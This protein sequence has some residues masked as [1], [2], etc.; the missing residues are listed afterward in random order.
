ML[1]IGPIGWAA[2]PLGLPIWVIGTTV[3]LLRLPAR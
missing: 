1:V 2:L 3:F